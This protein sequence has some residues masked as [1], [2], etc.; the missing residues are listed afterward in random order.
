M[1]FQLFIFLFTLLLFAFTTNS[2]AQKDTIHQKRDSI[3]KMSDFTHEEYAAWSTILSDW[4]KN[5]FF[6]CLKKQ[7]L[8][9]T[10]DGCESIYLHVNMNI[11]STGKLVKYTITKEKMCGEKFRPELKEGF[12][13]YFENLIFPPALQNKIINVYL[14]EC[15]KC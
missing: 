15:L 8:R 11:D 12:L 3:I 13:N 7:K 2:N 5:I 10:C 9:L 6:D 1:K 14:G 4:R